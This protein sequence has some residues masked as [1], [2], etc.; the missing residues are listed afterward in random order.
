M[1]TKQEKKDVKC[2]R[3]RSPNH[4]LISLKEAI[5]RAD[6]LYKEYGR[7]ALPVAKAHEKWGY[8]EHGS[9]GNQCV[10]TLKAFGLLDVEGQSEKRKVALSERAD[11][12]LRH[13][14]DYSRLLKKAALEPQIH[15]ELIEEYA[16]NGL[17]PNDL[18]R[19]YLVWER[20]AGKFNED[21]VDAF[22][23][24]FRETLGLAGIE[25]GD[26]IEGADT[27]IE[28]EKQQREKSVQPSPHQ[29]W[30]TGDVPMREL[31]ITLPTL[32]IATLKVPEKMSKLE[33]DEMM[34][35]LKKW[36]PALVQ[37]ASDTSSQDNL[38]NQ[39]DA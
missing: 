7:H 28:K 2:T 34:D 15:R 37:T 23:A 20:G 29:V 33:Y 39:D 10:A 3:V 25:G 36:E 26:I 14:P 21:T 5:E 35:T 22:I 4:P 38:P 11:R 9:I 27:D 30:G 32:V 1:A 13:A 18:L 17:P 19:Q 31:P 24:N 16:K 6:Q 8:K 12:I